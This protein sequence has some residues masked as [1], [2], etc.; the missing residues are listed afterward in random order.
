MPNEKLKKYNTGD[1]VY[2]PAER[3]TSGADFSHAVVRG[4]VEKTKNEGR[5]IVARL[6]DGA[7]SD[8]LATSIV[9]P[10]P[11]ILLIK[12]GDYETERGLLD[13][14]AK[15][16]IQFLRLLLPDDMIVRHDIR[17]M[18]ELS[19]IWNQS[20]SCHETVILIGHGSKTGVH[21]GVDGHVNV[22]KLV[23][24]FEDGVGQAKKRFLSLCCQTG[25]A[26]FARV[27]SDSK[28][29]GEL[30]APFH[31]IHGAVASQFLQALFVCRLYKGEVGKVSFRHAN[32]WLPSDI[33]FRRWIAG[34][35]VT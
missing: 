19:M 29:C 22:A 11:S 17:S 25:Y 9:L 27:F 7:A 21:F 3:L 14:L 12:I 13:P 1:T 2:I 31:S 32:K 8:W 18:S 24:V 10:D 35:I 16:S 33:R 15:S 26:R 6:P 34:H 5:S 4:T 28:N 30:I 23:K 20:G